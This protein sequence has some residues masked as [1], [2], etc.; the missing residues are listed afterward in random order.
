MQLCYANNRK[1]GADWILLQ[2]GLFFSIGQFVSLPVLAES[3]W[4]W[5]LPKLTKFVLS[6]FKLTEVNLF[7][8]TEAVWS[9]G[10]TVK[11]MPVV[12]I[13][14]HDSQLLSRQKTQS[15]NKVSFILRWSSQMSIG[16]ETA[17][18]KTPA[19]CE[20]RQAQTSYKSR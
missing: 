13:S 18:I 6:Y 7:V 12:L 5:R 16:N 11:S 2:K 20:L 10:S 14:K 15:L 9:K 17:L 8:S 4:H 3:G 19:A 1:R